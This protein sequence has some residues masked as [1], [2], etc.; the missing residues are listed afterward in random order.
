MSKTPQEENLS[1]FPPLTLDVSGLLEPSGAMGVSGT[2]L[3][4][5]NHLSLLIAS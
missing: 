3:Y 1:A 5:T 2:L 4:E